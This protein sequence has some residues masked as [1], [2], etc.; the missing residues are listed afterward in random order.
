MRPK[1]IARLVH[2]KVMG[3]LRTRVNLAKLNAL[4]SQ[5]L[6]DIG[7]NKTEFHAAAD[8]ATPFERPNQSAANGRPDEACCS[9]PRIH[10]SRSIDMA[11]SMSP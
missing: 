7:L 8:P 4:D 2:S 10:R 3:W 5:M 9:R 1:A 6:K 11:C